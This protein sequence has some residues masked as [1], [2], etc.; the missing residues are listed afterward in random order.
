[1][2]GNLSAPVVP[3][4]SQGVGDRLR[5]IVLPHVQGLPPESSEE[6]VVA[7]VSRPVAR[8]LGGP[9]VRICPR[10]DTMRRTSVPEAAVNED[11]HAE[12]HQHDVR[13]TRQ[14]SP[15]DTEPDASPVQGAAQDQLRTC[16]A[17]GHPLH[18]GPYLRA[19]RLRCS[20]LVPPKHK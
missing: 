5:I 3:A 10:G 19:R 7:V 16:V 9:E 1:M 14:I 6:R 18:E 4:E 11:R 20:H 13:P 17:P 15:V 2:S 8:D 12:A